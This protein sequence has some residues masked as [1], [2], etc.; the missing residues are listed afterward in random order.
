MLGS[1]AGPCRRAWEARGGLSVGAR[2]LQLRTGWEVHTSSL[3]KV[4]GP[5]DQ[6]VLLNPCLFAAPEVLAGDRSTEKADI[7]SLGVVLWVS[8]PEGAMDA[9]VAVLR[10]A[11]S[12]PSP[13]ASRPQKTASLRAAA[14][15]I[16]ACSG[17]AN[18]GSGNLVSSRLRCVQSR[19][20]WSR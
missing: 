8:R 1:A 14:A 5:P 20:S 4:A 3:A 12:P 10:A 2:A 6:L 9:E 15:R 13:Q 19:R 7:Y 11:F 17:P 18:S 16:A